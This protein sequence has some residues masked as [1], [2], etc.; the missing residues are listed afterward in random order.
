MSNTLLKAEVQANIDALT[1]PTAAAVLLQNAVDTVGLDLDL[2][3]II[4]VHSSATTAITGSTSANDI[5]ALNATGI[6]L[7]VTSGNGSVTN[8]GDVK[9]L[10][11]D[12]VDGIHTPLSGEKWLKTGVI[13]TNAGLYPD[14]K[15]TTDANGT[16]VGIDT[17]EVDESTDLPIY[18]KI[19][20]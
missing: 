17:A 6:A 11:V 3:N 15:T 1:H 12:D 18:L 7:G 10:Y 13:E 2:G 8:V 20:D 5:T 19:K 16:Y 4:G 9:P 14:A